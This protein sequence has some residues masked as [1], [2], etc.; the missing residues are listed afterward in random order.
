[1][2]PEKSKLKKITC[3]NS[4]SHMYNVHVH[5]VIS[6]TY[7]YVGTSLLNVMRELNQ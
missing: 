4:N 1:M 5:V 7:V 3:D 2:A 6:D